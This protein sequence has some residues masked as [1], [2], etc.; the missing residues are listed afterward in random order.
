[1]FIKVVAQATTRGIMDSPLEYLGNSNP[2]HGTRNK[3]L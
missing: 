2:S 1:M 3:R